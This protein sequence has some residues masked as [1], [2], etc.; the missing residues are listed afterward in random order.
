MPRTPALW[1]SFSLCSQPP[2]CLLPQ[3][4]PYTPASS[5]APG[6]TGESQS[7]GLGERLRSAPMSQVFAPVQSALADPMGSGHVV[8]A[9]EVPP[10]KG[11]LDRYPKYR[12]PQ[13]SRILQAGSLY[14]EDHQVHCAHLAGE[15]RTDARFSLGGQVAVSCGFCPVRGRAPGNHWAPSGSSSDTL[16]AEAGGRAAFL[17]PKL[18]SPSPSWLPGVC[19]PPG[20]PRA[21]ERADP[22]DGT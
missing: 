1:G 15:S 8:M 10:Q 2:L 7:P 13:N 9:S 5:P 21:H 18:W 19:P 14:F 20:L 16:R 4:G 17:W 6:M 3:R 11:E 12:R 22:R